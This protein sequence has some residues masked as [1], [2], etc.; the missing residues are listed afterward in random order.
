[1]DVQLLRP[2]SRPETSVLE[3]QRL[4]AEDVCVEVGGAVEIADAEDDVVE[5][6]RTPAER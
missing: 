3:L 1:M 2:E 6:I 5:R 4:R